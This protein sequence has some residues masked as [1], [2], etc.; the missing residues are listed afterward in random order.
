MEFKTM[1][2][3]ENLLYDIWDHFIDVAEI[4]I[5]NYIPGFCDGV[6]FLDLEI[7]ELYG[8]S[9]TQGTIKNPDEPAVEIYRLDKNF[10][11]SDV[12]L[13][14]SGRTLLENETEEDVFKECFIET[15]GKNFRY[16]FTTRNIFN[17]IEEAG[18]YI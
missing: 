16:G 11:P 3:L 8:A 18:K 9:M 4:A 1:C 2:E 13:N 6:V 5:K 7:K 15:V 12:W 17:I 10:D 14:C